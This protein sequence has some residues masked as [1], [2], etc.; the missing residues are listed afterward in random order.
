MIEIFPKLEK[1]AYKC[2]ACGCQLSDAN[3][4]YFQGQFI[5]AEI[6]CTCCDEAYFQTLPIGKLADS[7][8]SFLRNGQRAK[9]SSS[10]D[11]LEGKQ[12]IKSILSEEIFIP[13]ISLIQ[14]KIL[15]KVVI[16]NCVGNNK[17]N[18]VENIKSIQ[19]FLNTNESIG[20]ILIVPNNYKWLFPEGIAEIWSVHISVEESGKR[21]TN[22]DNFVK[23]QF[24]RFETIFVSEKVNI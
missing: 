3:S 4:I 1:L 19:H 9:Y 18:L 16:F 11:S 12:L 2:P 21:L 8:I 24:S 17:T 7:P 10:I 22:L 14:Y 5:L 13:E 15:P 20:V 6:D 23:S